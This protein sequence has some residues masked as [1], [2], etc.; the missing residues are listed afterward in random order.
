MKRNEIVVRYG[1][2]NSDVFASIRTALCSMAPSSRVAVKLE[3]ANTVI[4]ED[5]LFNLH[6]SLNN[7]IGSGFGLAYFG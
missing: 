6:K 4:F 7:E 5:T 3:K 2:T 1:A